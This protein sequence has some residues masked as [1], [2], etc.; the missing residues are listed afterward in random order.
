M[1][2]V[3]MHS[4]G[5]TYLQFT[6]FLCYVFVVYGF[7]VRMAQI[8]CCKCCLACW[9]KLLVKLCWHRFTVCVKHEIKPPSSRTFITFV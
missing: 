7:Q 8:C 1:H 3:L 2:V 4:F 9:L 6:V 5:F